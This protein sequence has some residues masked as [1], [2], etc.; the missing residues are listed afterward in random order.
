[1]ARPAKTFLLLPLLFSTL[2]VVGGQSS[3]AAVVSNRGLTAGPVVKLEVSP[4]PHYTVTWLRPTSGP[5][6]ID[7]YLLQLRQD[8]ACLRLFRIICE[9]CKASRT[10]ESS[11]PCD[12][13]ANF[14]HYPAALIND[15]DTMMNFTLL[16]LDPRTQ[17]EAVVTPFSK[18]GLGKTSST[19]F[20][21]GKP[22]PPL[23]DYSGTSLL[24]S[25]RGVIPAE[26]HVDINICSSCV[27]DKSHGDPTVAALLVCVQSVMGIC[28]TPTINKPEDLDNV[29]TWRQAEAIGF[30]TAYRVTPEDWLSD[31]RKALP[32]PL[33]FSVGAD[34]DCFTSDEYCNGYLPSQSMIT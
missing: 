7:G 18:D 1:M 20:T 33:A 6:T 8:N 10:I 11:P 34:R 17:Y 14:V 3:E 28:L 25:R 30:K 26:D 16:R 31:L 27:L 21:T 29:G 4:P 13:P 2:E 19:T 22:I 5:D 9:D 23:A 24:W 12:R 15:P 32:D